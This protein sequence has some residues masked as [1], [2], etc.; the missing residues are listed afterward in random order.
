MERRRK[1]V[2][3]RTQR[4]A[5]RCS[6]PNGWSPASPDLP[7]LKLTANPFFCT[8]KSEVKRSSI[9]FPVELSVSPLAVGPQNLTSALPV[10]TT[11][12]SYMQL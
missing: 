1:E 2:R 12:R 5:P 8:L 4:S 6:D 7:R 11:T 9:T 3:S 10:W